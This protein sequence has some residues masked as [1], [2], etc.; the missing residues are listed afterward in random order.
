M[1]SRLLHVHP[2][3]KTDTFTLIP[4]SPLMKNLY[5][6]YDANTVFG[7]LMLLLF[8]TTDGR[9]DTFKLIIPFHEN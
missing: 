6:Q 5:L 7:A 8:I 4:L 9:M 2:G 1:F 3:G